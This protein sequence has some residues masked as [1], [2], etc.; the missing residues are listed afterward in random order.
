MKRAVLLSVSVL[1]VAMAA[2]GAWL[3]IGAERPY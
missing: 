2:A 3:L 1:V